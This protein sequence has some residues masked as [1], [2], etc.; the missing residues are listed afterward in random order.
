MAVGE[1]GRRWDERPR[2]HRSNLKCLCCNFLFRG[3]ASEA[4]EGENALV[5]MHSFHNCVQSERS[6]SY[7][8]MPFRFHFNVCN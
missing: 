7:C 8:A 1:M 2:T 6:R 5:F 3:G 4:V